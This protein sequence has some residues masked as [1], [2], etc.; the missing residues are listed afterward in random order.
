M[1]DHFLAMKACSHFWI[2]SARLKIAYAVLTIFLLVSSCF[3]KSNN[4]LVV[5]CNGQCRY[6]DSEL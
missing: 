5:E 1:T 2:S 4:R 3:T 6:S